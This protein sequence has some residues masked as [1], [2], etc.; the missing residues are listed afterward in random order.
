MTKQPRVSIGMPVYNGARFIGEAVRSIQAQ[1]FQ[2]FE[3][4]ISD[5]A[6]TDETQEICTRLAAQDSRIRYYRQAR[7]LGAGVAFVRELLQRYAVRFVVAR[8]T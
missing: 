7:N 8:R 1:T 3:V 2:D 6:S 4:V 5:N